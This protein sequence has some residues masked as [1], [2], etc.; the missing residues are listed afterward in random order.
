MKPISILF[1]LVIAVM[2]LTF[3]FE[4]SHADPR[5]PNVTLPT[6]AATPRPMSL[7]LQKIVSAQLRINRYFHGSVVPKLKTCWNSL[8]GKGNIAMKYTYSRTANEKW[9]VQQVSV[10]NSSL[11]TVVQS[12]ALRCM[13]GAVAGTSFSIE[14]DDGTEDA[15]VLNW[16]WP[17]PLPPNAEQI[18]ARM[19]NNDGGGAGSKGGCD[20]EGAI[21]GC[22]HCMEDN[23]CELVCVGAN[24]CE[25]KGI[26]GRVGQRRATKC[27]ERG[28]CVSGGPF[29]S[30][31][32]LSISKAFFS[33]GLDRDDTAELSAFP[34][35]FSSN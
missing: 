10:K 3:I 15:F 13:K 22:A 26:V 27:I 31:G 11:P 34:A 21:A 25:A 35:L 28:K 29:G 30:A 8:Q 32:S 33:I 4:R 5:M 7:T 1:A 17:I 2:A 16:N 14:R 24:E 9:A 18:T 19:F 23:F 20:G 6:A 12:A